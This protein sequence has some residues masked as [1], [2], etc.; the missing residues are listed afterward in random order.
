MKLETIFRP[1]GL[2][3]ALKRPHKCTTDR[4]TALAPGWAPASSQRSNSN[5]RFSNDPQVVAPTQDCQG[6]LN[7]PTPSGSA[8][9]S[10][11]KSRSLGVVEFGGPWPSWNPAVATDFHPVNLK[12][13]WTACLDNRTAMDRVL[14]ALSLFLTGL[15]GSGEQLKALSLP[16]DSWR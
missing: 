1:D 2:E 3:G 12:D 8:A 10:R 9:E 6:S 16:S 13:H 7:S 4:S 5:Q 14:R 15:T 11:E